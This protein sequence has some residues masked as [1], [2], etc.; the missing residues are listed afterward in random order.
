[1]ASADR[2]LSDDMFKDVGNNEFILQ[3]T[4]P[5]PYSYQSLPPAGTE[6][7]GPNGQPLTG[8]KLSLTVTIDGTFEVRPEG[9][10]G[11]WERCKKDGGF[12]VYRPDRG[13]CFKL[14]CQ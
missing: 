3:V 12:A 7:H 14:L 11:A 4:N 9:T 8:D 1:M 6:L 2:Y 13:A 5:L 10:A